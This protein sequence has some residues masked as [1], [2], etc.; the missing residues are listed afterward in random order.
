MQ[1]A[2]I[3]R[4]KVHTP[5]M[6]I[7]YP[8]PG[9]CQAEQSF[10]THILLPCFPP[11][12]AS[13]HITYHIPGLAPNSS[14]HYLV[15]PSHFLQL[16]N[17]YPS[18]ILSIQSQFICDNF[19]N[20]SFQPLGSHSLHFAT[21]ALYMSHCYS[22]HHIPLRKCVF[23]PGSLTGPESWV[24][25]R[26]RHTNRNEVEKWGWMLK[27]VCVCVYVNRWVVSN[28]FWPHGL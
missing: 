14:L 6:T 28:S 24:A 13:Q 11:I 7:D 3:L 12:E 17:S 5:S 22:I 4:D 27:V 20:L 19:C 10:C 21:T 18:S 26:S 16:T 25:R 23:L 9:P 15:C 8:C 2:L 1:F